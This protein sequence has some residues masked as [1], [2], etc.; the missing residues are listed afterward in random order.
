MAKMTT[1]FADAGTAFLVRK[2]RAA[3]ASGRELLIPKAVVDRLARAN[4][5][6]VPRESQIRSAMSFWR[7]SRKSGNP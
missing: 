3:I 5:G 7:R 2:A 1:K 6:R 4:L